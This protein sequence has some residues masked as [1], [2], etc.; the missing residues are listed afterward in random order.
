ARV[1]PLAAVDTLVTDSGVDA[2]VAAEVEEAGVR[3]VLS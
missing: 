1:A 2:T 3:V